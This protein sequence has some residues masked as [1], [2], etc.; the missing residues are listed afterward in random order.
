MTITWIAE[1]EP[2]NGVKKKRHKSG[3][4]PGNQERKCFQE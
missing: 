3:R 2:A 1:K 4:G